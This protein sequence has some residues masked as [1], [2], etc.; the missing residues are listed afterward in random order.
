VNVAR[1][2][3]PIFS[4]VSDRRC[5]SASTGSISSTLPPSA[6]SFAASTF[7][8]RSS[9]SGSRL[10]DSIAVSSFSVSSSAGF[11]FCASAST[12]WSAARAGSSAASAQKSR[13]TVTR[14]RHMV[15]TRAS[16]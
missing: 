1:T 2:I 11:S 10:P 8:M 12:G 5:V 4:G 13:T 3:L 16:D 9:S 6:A 7:A 14:I 15:F